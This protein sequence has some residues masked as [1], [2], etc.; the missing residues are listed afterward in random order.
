MHKQISRIMFSQQ[1]A[2]IAKNAATWAAETVDLITEIGDTERSETV[3]R[4]TDEMRRRLDHLDEIAG[5][6]T[7]GGKR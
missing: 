7:V 1:C 4:F 2:Y 6:T 3:F 5:R